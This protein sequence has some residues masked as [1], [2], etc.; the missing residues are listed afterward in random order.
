MREHEA[1]LKQREHAVA[2][3]EARLAERE[4]LIRAAAPVA[5]AGARPA[6]ELADD[7]AVA[8]LTTAPFKM[9]R[10]VLLGRK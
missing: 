10:A 5:P 7:S 3:R 1:M 6:A 8:R 2:E 9:A 4:A